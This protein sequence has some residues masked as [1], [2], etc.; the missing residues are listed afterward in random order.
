MLL[1][2]QPN[3]NLGQKGFFSIKFSEYIS[4]F[5]DSLDSLNL[6]NQYFSN[7]SQNKSSTTLMYGIVSVSNKENAGFEA[8]VTNV[9]KSDKNYFSDLGILL[10]FGNFSGHN[11]LPAE[12]RNG[13]PLYGP[14]S[15]AMNGKENLT[16]GP[17]KNLYGW[18]KDCF[19][20][21]ETTVNKLSTQEKKVF[22]MVFVDNS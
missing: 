4:Q 9:R 18:L 6:L 12:A 19:N 16:N 15:L 14:L 21:F 5:A 7:Y 13:S 1:V 20:K 2:L 8:F 22:P 17:V 10:K 3:V 11:F